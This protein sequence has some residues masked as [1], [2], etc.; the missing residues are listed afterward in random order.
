[1]D[2][3]EFS[4]KDLRFQFIQPQDH[5]ISCLCFFVTLKSLHVWHVIPWLSN[6]DCA[7]ELM[8]FVNLY[9]HLGFG[10][11]FTTGTDYQV[12]RNNSSL[13]RNTVSAKGQ[14]DF[15]CHR[16]TSFQFIKCL[17]SLDSCSV[18]SPNIHRIYLGSWFEGNNRK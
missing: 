7:D 1:M 18:L 8:I 16:A 10:Q 4:A 5:W 17:I 15:G 3:L 11:G 9:I 6:P 2:L 13:L 14:I 12:E